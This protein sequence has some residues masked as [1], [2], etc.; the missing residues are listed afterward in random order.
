MNFAGFVLH[1]VTHFHWITCI[2]DVCWELDILSLSLSFSVV[3]ES[4][5]R[6]GF[7][8]QI[9][10]YSAHSMLRRRLFAFNRYYQF[11]RILCCNKR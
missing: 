8:T 5:T 6:V 3:L 9:Q 10:G 7:M 11:N 1:Y 4:G 2:I